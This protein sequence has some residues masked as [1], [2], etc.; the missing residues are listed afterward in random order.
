MRKL[1]IR[2]DIEKIST[3]VSEIKST[4]IIAYVDY[5]NNIHIIQID[6]KSN[7]VYNRTL[8]SLPTTHTYSSLDSAINN[9][10]NDIQVYCFTTQ[11]DFAVWMLKKI[12]VG[13]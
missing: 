1:V 4:D 2:S 3:R 9:I 12:G 10:T 8:K 13:D 6:E 11:H 7:D 5:T